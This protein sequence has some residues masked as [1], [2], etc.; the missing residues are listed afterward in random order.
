MEISVWFTSGMTL[1]GVIVGSLITPYVT[2]QIEK[3][4]IKINIQPTLIKLMYKLYQLKGQEFIIHNNLE[5]YMKGIRDSNEDLTNMNLTAEQRTE[6]QRQSM[7]QSERY[8][9]FFDRQEK[10]Y[11]ELLEVKSEIY[12]IVQQIKL[13]FGDYIYKRVENSVHDKIKMNEKV[14]ILRDYIS[15]NR[16]EYLNVANSFNDDTNKEMD[17]IH[18]EG[19]K[20]INKVI[21]ILR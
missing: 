7:N 12:S 11:D 14:K 16:E 10:N 3:R 15:L 17:S 5:F 9:N 13:H 8:K 4:K 2:S 1:L 21:D 18:E 20:L 6:I 19:G